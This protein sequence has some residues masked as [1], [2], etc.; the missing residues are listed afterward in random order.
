[1]RVRLAQRD[2]DRGGGWPVVTATLAL[3][4]GYNERSALVPGQLE[5]VHRTLLHT[6]LMGT[7]HLPLVGL[8]FVALALMEW[9]DH[10]Y[11]IDPSLHAVVRT[12]RPPP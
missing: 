6:P 8:F 2:P 5:V 4:N 7:L 1:M 11:P 3:Y 10:G 12:P 9:Y